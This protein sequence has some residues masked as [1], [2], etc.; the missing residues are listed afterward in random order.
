[1]AERSTICFTD[2]IERKTIR[3]LP[4]NDAVSAAGSQRNKWQIQMN[5]LCKKEREK[6]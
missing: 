4:K 3:F 2:N 6:E 1:M 5:E